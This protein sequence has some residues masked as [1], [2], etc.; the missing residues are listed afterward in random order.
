MLVHAPTAILWWA[1]GEIE[2]TKGGE[3]DQDV[4]GVDSPGLERK[5]LAEAGMAEIKLGIMRSQILER[6]RVKEIHGQFAA[7]LRQAGERIGKQFG[8]TASRIMHDAMD[9]CEA[10]VEREFGGNGFSGD[11][12]PG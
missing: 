4:S 3:D 5:R 7:I 11:D 8:P 12:L 9:D 10:V 2:R 6:E 1:R